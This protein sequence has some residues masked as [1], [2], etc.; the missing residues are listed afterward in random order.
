MTKGKFCISRSNV[1]IFEINGN[2]TE[3]F[4][5]FSVATYK[6]PADMIPPVPEPAVEKARGCGQE[7]LTKLT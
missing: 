1:A 4:C 5:V 3:L 2:R 7:N 6:P